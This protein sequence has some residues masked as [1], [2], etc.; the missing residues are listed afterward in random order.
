MKPIIEGLGKPMEL[1]LYDIKRPIVYDCINFTCPSCGETFAVKD[2]S[3]GDELEYGSFY[4]YSEC[5]ECGQEFED[6][7]FEVSATVTIKEK[8]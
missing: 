3:H 6:M 5:N 2:L 8:E 7:E 4:G 1:D